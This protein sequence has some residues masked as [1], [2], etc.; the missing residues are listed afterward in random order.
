LKFL[1]RG[2]RP[3][4]PDHAPDEAPEQGEVLMGL[5]VMVAFAMLWSTICLVAGAYLFGPAVCQ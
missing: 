1:A 2:I 4:N 5:A 3:E